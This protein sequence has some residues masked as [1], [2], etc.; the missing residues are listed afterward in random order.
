MLPPSSPTLSS[1]SSSSPLDGSSNERSHRPVSHPSPSPSPSPP[2]PPTP[3]PAPPPKAAFKAYGQSYQYA[4]NWQNPLPEFIFNSSYT[5]PAQIGVAVTTPTGSPTA[6]EVDGASYDDN[7]RNTTYTHYTTNGPTSSLHRS[8]TVASKETGVIMQPPQEE[9]IW[10]E[11]EEAPWY[12]R[13]TRQ[14][15]LIAGVSFLGILAVLLAILGAMGK[16]TGSDDAD[17]FSSASSTT[18][19]TA[20]NSPTSSTTS[21][22]SRPQ[23]TGDVKI[24]CNDKSTFFTEINMVFTDKSDPDYSNATATA[25]ECCVACLEASSAADNDSSCAGWLFDPGNKFTPCVRMFL[26]GG[27]GNNGGGDKQCPQGKAAST[28][29]GG[30]GKKVGGM[31]PCSGRAISG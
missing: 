20:T 30:V 25:E 13:I 26:N 18:S 17:T 9:A 8:G 22:T 28:T 12:K 10:I 27:D 14:Q 19:S 15:W 21:T 5:H 11:P 7:R 4:E 3:A 24:S 1:V 6:A 16:L 29:F 2:P 31:G 23:P